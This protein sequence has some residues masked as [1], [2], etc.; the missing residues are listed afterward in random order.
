M[1]V[2]FDGASAG[3]GLDAEL[4]GLAADVLQRCVRSTVVNARGVEVG[5]FES[6]DLAAAHAGVGGEVQCRVEAMDDAAVEEL[7]E[8]RRG[9]RSGGRAWRAVGVGC[10]RGG[11]RCG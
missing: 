1:L 7:V 9:P 10:G 4:D 11:R 3:A 2:E 6:D 8:L 5:P